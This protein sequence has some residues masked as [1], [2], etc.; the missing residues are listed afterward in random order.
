[1]AAFVQAYVNI[2]EEPLKNSC[3]LMEANLIHVVLEMFFVGR[4]H[5][6]F[7][8]DEHLHDCQCPKPK[9]TRAFSRFFTCF[10]LTFHCA[11]VFVCCMYSMCQRETC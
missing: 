5:V 11:C 7:V 3:F 1:M 6:D 8:S 10:S 4:R 2:T 9:K